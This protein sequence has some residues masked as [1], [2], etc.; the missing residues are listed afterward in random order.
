MREVRKK[1]GKKKAK[2]EGTTTYNTRDSPVVTDLT[3]NLALSD[4]TLGEQ[5]GSRVFQKV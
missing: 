3:T 1:K 2:K 5:T 4:L